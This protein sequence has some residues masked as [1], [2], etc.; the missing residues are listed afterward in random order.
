MSTRSSPGNS[1]LEPPSPPR[2]MSLL[3]HLIELRTRLLYS[4]L[5][6]L[7]GFLVLFPFSNHLFTFVAQP[8]L[9][10]LPAGSQMVAI[11]PASP[12]ITPMK[13]TLVLA[14]FVAI[15]ILLYQ[16]WAFVAPGLYRHE[17]RLAIPLLISSIVLFYVGM[18]FA[19]F[20]VFPLVFGF[21]VSVLPEGV[22][23]ATDINRYLDF[24]LKMFFAFGVA[25][26]VPV[27]T[28]LLIL[29]GITTAAA[30][31]QLRAYVI[32]GAFVVGMLLTPP[33]VFSQTLLAVPMWLLFELGLYLAGFLQRESQAAP[34]ATEPSPGF[35]I[36]RYRPLSAEEMDE[37][38]NSD[39]GIPSATSTPPAPLKE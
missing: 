8:L 28:V 17:K 7:I 13:L 32:V 14:V 27:A 2:E 12:F 38:M 3:D 26:E 31:A 29:S 21:F 16:L 20:M 19:Y 34:P 36:N 37:I 25:F 6:I 1:A 15:P 18:A 35:D 39:G 11:D 23:M 5:S 33:D 24:V 22:A 4:V 9:R 10:F 30:L